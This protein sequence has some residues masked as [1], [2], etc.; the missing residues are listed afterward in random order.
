[1]TDE[2][3]TSKPLPEAFKVLL[4]EK[5]VELFEDIAST[6]VN[7]KIFKYMESLDEVIYYNDFSL[8]DRAKASIGIQQ[9][10]VNCLFRERAL[11][12]RLK[13]AKEKIENEIKDKQKEDTERFKTPLRAIFDSD[14][15][16]KKVNKGIAVQNEVVL[17]LEK[18]IDNLKDFTYS[19]KNVVEYKKLSNY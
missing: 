2:V 18:S 17:F 8:E 5:V 7:S 14:E 1:M 16:L 6:D 15:S 12:N 4:P 10:F 19:I 11:L 13:E 3:K 9:G